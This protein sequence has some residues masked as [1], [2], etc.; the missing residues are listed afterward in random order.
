M[1]FRESDIGAN[2]FIGLLQDKFDIDRTAFMD[3]ESRR[4]ALSKGASRCFIPKNDTYPPVYIFENLDGKTYVLQDE[5]EGYDAEL[6]T[7]TLDR[8]DS[9]YE[10]EQSQSLR[11]L[12]ICEQYIFETLYLGPL[13]DN[14]DG[15]D[16]LCIYGMAHC[17]PAASASEEDVAIWVVGD[18]GDTRNHSTKT[19]GYMPC[20]SGDGNLIFPTYKEAQAKIDSLNNSE[21]LLRVGEV[22][23]PRYIITA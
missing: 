13:D 2:Q 11:C 8:N 1:D 10:L 19:H 4:D 17:I 12:N 5:I 7:M 16:V 3:A 21:Y 18:Y 20:D 14:D 15:Y 23:R 9:P 22:S 6:F